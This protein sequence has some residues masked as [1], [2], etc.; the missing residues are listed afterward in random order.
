MPRAGCGGLHKYERIHKW[1]NYDCHLCSV[2]SVQELPFLGLFR[3]LAKKEYQMTENELY[4]V[5]KMRC[6]WCQIVY[7]GEVECMEQIEVLK[8]RVIDLCPHCQ[9]IG[10]N[11]VVGECNV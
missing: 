3:Q 9:L 10:N 5:F 11:L 6:E 1:H 7:E 2:I 8:T 4:R